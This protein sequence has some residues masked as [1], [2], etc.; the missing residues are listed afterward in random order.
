MNHR[1]DENA[2]YVAKKRQYMKRKKNKRTALIA[3]LCIAITIVW[4]MI[5]NVV[6]DFSSAYTPAK[7]TAETF[8]ETTVAETEAL[9]TERG[10]F[11]NDAATSQAELKRE[12][13]SRGSLIL[14]SDHLGYKL[15]QNNAPLTTVWG[16]KSST[17]YVATATL[18]L[19]SD[20]FY[21]ADEMFCDY[22]AANSNG[23][24][25]ITMGYAPADAPICCTEHG[26]GYAFD[27][28]VYTKSGA[29]LRLAEAG[30]IYNWI[31]ENCAKYG[32]VLR[33][34]REKTNVTGMPY[35]ADHFRY[36]GKGHAQYM[37][38]NDLA[39]EDYIG[40][41]QKHAYGKKHLEFSYDGVD[42]EVFYVNIPSGTD[43]VTIEIPADVSYT[44]SGDN[45]SGVIVTLY[46]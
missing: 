1:P 9:T 32:F 46:K 17:Y 14:V 30:G 23:D 26:T 7:T 34:D 40:E 31:Y 36:V 27:V 18:Q 19:A 42:Y 38:E 33:Y 15:P 29:S 6:K 12:D 39:L 13:I 21:A 25:Q 28:N 44:L 35:D 20:A 3:V 10:S 16:N 5:I 41:L 2:H 43:S 8:A 45:I 4:I 22:Y 24:Y 11:Y 37:A